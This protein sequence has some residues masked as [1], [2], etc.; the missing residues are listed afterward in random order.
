MAKRDKQKMDDQ[1]H[2]ELIGEGAELDASIKKQKKSLDQIKEL[3][4][5]WYVSRRE[6]LGDAFKKTQKDGLAQVTFA[7]TDVFE[8]I[9]VIEMEKMLEARGLGDKLFTCIKVDMTAL[10]KVLGA[11]DIEQLRGESQGTKYSMRFKIN[12]E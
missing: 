3:L 7:E 10:K 6:A 2:I 9:S 4:T 8:P 1:Y 12:K 11:A 5:D